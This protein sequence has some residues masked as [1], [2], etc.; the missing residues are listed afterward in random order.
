MS[1]PPEISAVLGLLLQGLMATE[2]SVRLAAETLLDAEWRAPERVGLLLL[3][4]AQT[5]AGGADDSTRAFAAVLFR[6]TAIRTPQQLAS[7][8]DRTFGV[9]AADVQSQVRAVLLHGFVA[10]QAPAVRRKL[11]DAVAEVARDGGWREL[12]PA[13]LQAA[14]AGDSSVRELAF[15]V[16]ATLPEIIEKSMV[17]DVMPVFDGGFAD[18]SDEVRIAACTAF[19]AFF[20]ELPKSIWQAMAPLLPRLLN[21]LPMFLQSGE[22]D[23]L[24]EVLQSLIDLVE[25]AP[26]MFKAMFA[27]IVDFC[28]SLCKNGD[29]DAA[30][31]LAA[32]E[33][34][35]TF[36]E[37]SPAMC[38]QTPSYTLSMVLIN[39][40]MLTEVSRDDDDAADWNNDDNSE[41]CDDEPEYDA[42]RQSLDRVAL[43]LGGHALAAP[44][45]QYLPAMCQLDSWRDVFAALMALSSA[46]EG[47]CDVLATEIPKLLD[48]VLPTLSHPHLRV[49]YACCNALGQMSTDFADVIQRTSGDRILPALVSKL[50]AKSVPRVQAHAA[51]ALVNFCEAAS[52]EILEPYLDDLLNNLLGLL[53]SPKRYVQEQVLTTIAI[54]ADA[55]EK[56]FL[57]YHSTLLPMLIDFLKSD[58]GPENRMLTAKCIECA[59]LIA[60]AVGKDNFSAHTQELINI[61][62][63]LQNSV[64]EPDDPVKLFLEQGW[65][66][67][68][69]IIGDDFVAYLPAV[70]PPLMLAAKAAQ[71]I[72]LLEEEEAEEFNTN[73]EWDVINI[74][75]KLIAVHTAALDEKAAAMDLLR[76]YATQLKGHFFPWVKE[77]VQ[78]IALPALDFYLHDGVRGSAALTLAALLRS[79]IHATSSNSVETL[80]IW[81]QMCEKLVDALVNDPVPELLVAYYTAITDCL[82]ALEPSSLS[83]EQMQS[84]S[85]AIKKNLTEIYERIK[86]RESDDDE[87]Q[88]EV[89]DEDEDYTDEELLDE[90]NKVIS[91][92][93]KNA[94]SLFLP[95]FQLSL[96]GLVSTFISDEN[97]HIKLCGLCIICDV[98]EHAG[99]EFNQLDYLRYIAVDC[100]TSSQASIRQ[101]AAYAMGVA[102]QYGGN[103]YMEICVQTLPNLFKI[104][105]FPDARAEENINATENCIAAIPKICANFSASIADLDKVLHEWISLL[106]IVQDD[107]AAA[108]AYGFLADLIENQHAAVMGQIPKVVDSVLEAI[109][110]RAISGAVAEKVVPRVRALLGTLPQ[111]KAMSMVQKYSASPEVTKYFS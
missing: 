91:A 98:L 4:L 9:V 63:E 19:V 17:G 43:K 28:L 53:L 88:E 92:I 69:R 7:I 54:I 76:I 33:L 81:A 65:G 50:T 110:H 102:A 55:A 30:P 103:N 35:T 42:A 29:L 10:P 23:A 106:P 64:V 77:I 47:C 67:L 34:L 82:Q 107:E 73:E 109:N 18:G 56:K 111:D 1:M 94:K 41:D 93:F 104:A 20:R 78:E 5:A 58:L 101:A 74:A 38:K 100:L 11:A 96:A 72:S 75:G 31:R 3:F 108:F 59:T 85:A 8:A 24:A 86:L 99:P 84:I 61:M 62:G 45:F 48:M 27:T 36:A 39:L 37:V 2:N 44:L 22:T 6:R 49:Q 70:L 60:V 46:A 68:C 83:A 80:T 97:S 90:I 57:K 105:T 71:D 25:L 14:Q 26:K 89:A 52:K 87:Y 40:S 95:E 12:L 13:V 21:S 79:T 66:R 32:L 16:L 15:R 51:A